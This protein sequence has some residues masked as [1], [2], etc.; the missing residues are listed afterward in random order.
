MKGNQTHLPLDVG[1]LVDNFVES[2]EVALTAGDPVDLREFLPATSHACFLDVSAEL[3]RVDLEHR[4]ERGLSRSLDDYREIVPELFE[5]KSHLEE[6]AFEQYRLRRLAGE[7]VTSDEY[8]ARFDIDTHAWAA[9][10]TQHG[11]TDDTIATGKRLVRTLDTIEN[12]PRVGDTF[13][14]FELVDELGAGTFSQVFL[15]RQGMLA[16]R[17]VALKISAA[18]A[19]EADKLARL[20]HT[21]IV[22]IYSVEHEHDLHGVCMPFLGAA[23]LADV[24]SSFKNAGFTTPETLTGG[25]LLD[26]ITAAQ[27]TETVRDM[28]LSWPNAANVRQASYPDA[29]AA[30]MARVAKGLAFAH[31]RGI[32][33]RD[34]K[35]G[36]VLLASDG[37]PRLL[38]FNLSDDVLHDDPAHLFV[39]GTLPYMSPEQ[40]G[41]LIDGSIS[42]PASDVYAFGVMCHEL[43]TLRPPFP[44]RRGSFDEVVARMIAD[45]KLA[46]PSV[47]DQNPQVSCD[48]ATIVQKCLNPDPAKRY[49][50]ASELSEDLSRHVANL[51]LH[52]A[53]NHSAA[54]R[55]R[56][57]SRRHPRITSGSTVALLASV[58]LISVLGFLAYRSGQLSGARASNHYHEFQAEYAAT[59]AAL[60]TPTVDPSVRLEVLENARQALNHYNVGENSNWRDQ[61]NYRLLP[62]SQ[63]Q[64]LNEQL[65][66]LMY[67]GVE[68]FRE[69]DMTR[70]DLNMAQ[71]WNRAARELAGSAVTR[72]LAEQ[73]TQ[74][75]NWQ[76]DNDGV[77][78]TDQVQTP[79]AEDEYL[80]AV[81]ALEQRDFD[82]AR[83]ILQRL[84]VHDP[85]DP[86]LWLLSGNASVG[87]R[88]YSHADACYSTY[89]GFLPEAYLGYFYRGLCRLDAKDHAGAEADFTQVIQLAPDLSAAWLNRALVR[90]AAGDLSGAHDDLTHAIDLGNVSSRAYLIRAKTRQQLNDPLGAAQDIQIGLERTP[91]DE[92]SWIARGTELISSDPQRALADFDQ[93]L[94]I[95][96]V[97]HTALQNSVYL[98]IEVLDQPDA[99][100][101]RLDRMLEIDAQDDVALAARA[102]L[103]ARLGHREAAVAGA[104][105][106]LKLSAPRTTYQ[107]ACVFALTSRLNPDDGDRA[108]AALATALSQ[109]PDRQRMARI[110]PDLEPI[111]ELA[112]YRVLMDAL[113]Q[114]NDLRKSPN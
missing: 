62:P 103:Q 105:Q 88:E 86:A 47:R 75:L 70:A 80:H 55:F 5:S 95:N 87:L 57:W 61:P 7:P 114:M 18:A 94:Q 4:H 19:G 97:S 9:W 29:V 78:L 74:L 44:I 109:E 6:I 100:L 20:Q 25:H 50:T 3:I 67:L 83:E 54:E 76:G 72:N 38:D 1:L 89:I 34:L 15:A 26:T 36:N 111:R 112:G 17:L 40:L 98:L 13:G 64:R 39:G 14:E 46:P 22:P 45:R 49:P 93:A 52:Y 69:G 8:A 81:A 12:M 91:N 107:A 28:K 110:D 113:E 30:I 73:Q 37:E 35:P 31:R 43:L 104:E 66:E 84:R 21:N 16:N 101:L 56:K 48:L 41:T 63:R 71:A 33:H 51:P 42:Q 27:H 96:P 77:G 23:T 60:S 102:V 11:T 92:L 90:R 2:Y 99:A 53:V 108:L 24:L 59:R 82:T 106:L 68:R 65:S 79:S 58:V 85:L 10:D 32:L